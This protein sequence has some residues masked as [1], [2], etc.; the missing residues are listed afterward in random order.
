[1][2]DKFFQVLKDKN[3]F[4]D[5]DDSSFVTIH[6]PVDLDE[7]DNAHFT[8]PFCVDRYKKGGA[9]YKTAHNIKHHHGFCGGGSRHP[10]CRWEALQYYK[11]PQFEFN[12]VRRNYKQYIV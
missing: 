10:H 8:C 7:N 11:A 3:I 12:L 6:I 1:M 2:S 4:Y 9:P 5:V